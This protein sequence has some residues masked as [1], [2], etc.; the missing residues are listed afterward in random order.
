MSGE[1]DITVVGIGGVALASPPASVDLIPDMV[2]AG[3]TDYFPAA[4][5]PGIGQWFDTMALRD[6]TLADMTPVVAGRHN[7][8][9]NVWGPWL[10]LW[11]Y[12]NGGANTWHSL[13]IEATNQLFPA[14]W[15]VVKSYHVQMRMGPQAADTSPMILTFKAPA[16]FIRIGFTRPIAPTLAG[17]P[18]LEFIVPTGFCGQTTWTP[19]PVT[20]L[21][22]QSGRD[23]EPETLFYNDSAVGV[24]IG[25]GYTPPLILDFSTYHAGIGAGLPATHA[26]KPVGAYVQPVRSDS[27]HFNVYNPAA[28]GTFD[29][30]IEGS[31][32]LAVWDQL[33]WDQSYIPVPGI[34]N[35]MD[36]NQQY[37]IAPGAV[38]AYPYP[39]FTGGYRPT[40]PYIRLSI[41]NTSGAINQFEFRVTVTN[42]RT[43]T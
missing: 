7:A 34:A 31:D 9:R 36:T 6:T 14:S 25:A 35:R 37:R 42:G 26:V 29:F 1:L 13:T 5:A 33:F 21:G 40:M 16:R 30:M 32:D 17:D 39:I 8:Y 19:E 3:G 41:V 4:V 22:F 38:D 24:G 15:E 28:A 10:S 2:L 18:R 12:H 43:G 27:M 20:G 11:Y 23:L